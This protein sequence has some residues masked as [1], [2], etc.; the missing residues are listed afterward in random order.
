MSHW[1]HVYDTHIS[2]Q[3]LLR[4]SKLFY[5]HAL[6]ILIFDDAACMCGSFKANK[7]SYWDVTKKDKKSL[8]SK[9]LF[10]PDLPVVVHHIL[11]FISGNFWV[12]LWCV[13]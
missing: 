5:Q 8:I 12:A 11:V 7:L 3:V 4:D 2:L 13:I 6:H 9:D 1:V 10:S